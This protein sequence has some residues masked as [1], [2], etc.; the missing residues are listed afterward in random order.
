MHISVDFDINRFVQQKS[1]SFYFAFFV[2]F[3]RR[4][5]FSKRMGSAH[6]CSGGRGVGLSEIGQKNCIFEN[7]G[8]REG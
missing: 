7:M 3:S 1:A 5:F 2:H 6:F 8:G 4:A